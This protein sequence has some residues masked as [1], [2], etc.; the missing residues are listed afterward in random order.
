MSRS[1]RLALPAFNVKDILLRPQSY[2]R[3]LTL[4]KLKLPNDYSINAVVQA[5]DDLKVSQKIQ[6]DVARKRNALKTPVPTTYSKE[7]KEQYRKVSDEVKAQQLLTHRLLASIP[8]LLPENC[9]L[10]N[11]TVY[12]SP[13]GTA[14]D[15]SRDHLEIGR[16]LG[17][18]DVAAGS[19]VS[20]PGQAYLIGEGARLEQA[21]INYALDVCADL[22]FQLVSPPSMVRREFA[23]A[24]G[25][26][27]RDEASQI[28]GIESSE[29]CLSGTA[30]IPLAAQLA[31]K[32]LDHL[33]LMH[34]GHSRSYRAEAGARGQESRGLYR[35]HE[36]SKVEMFVWCEPDAAQ[37]QLWLERLLQYQQ[38]IL[39]PILVDLGIPFRVL[40]IA[41]DDLGAPAYQKFDIEAWM[42]GR[43]TWGEL[44]SC[45]NCLDYQS[46]RLFT[47]NSDGKYV[48]T[49]NATALAAPRVILA[50]IES[51]YEKGLGVRIPKALQPY[52]KCEWIRDV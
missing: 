13:G 4:R 47:K 38:K 50:I 29:M 27:P 6:Q 12:Q 45:S 26:Q 30:E 2:Q 15:G 24:C 3:S 18:L 9:A 20:L 40:N 52:M 34:A 39:E 5:L 32:K 11:K 8:N 36:F 37:S 31:N 1:S 42:P 23:E 33:P 7:L 25:F 19:T 51:G 46:R 44:T 49:L 17:I 35:L 16:K 48:H 10:E 41:P 28:Y 14:A 21:L 22:G 43:G